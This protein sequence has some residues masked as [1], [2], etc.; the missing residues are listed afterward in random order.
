[1]GNRVFRAGKVITL[2][3]IFSFALTGLFGLPVLM[4]ALGKS[5]VDTDVTEGLYLLLGIEAAILIA[6]LFVSR[7]QGRPESR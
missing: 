2:I 3:G 6:G 5:K 1:M 7:W 4:L